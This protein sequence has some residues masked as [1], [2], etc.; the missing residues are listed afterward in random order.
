M[1]RNNFKFIIIITTH[2][3]FIKNKGEA[4]EI[5]ESTLIK[6]NIKNYDLHLSNHKLFNY[7][8]YPPPFVQSQ[9][10]SEIENTIN[11]NDI[12]TYNYGL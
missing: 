2:A 6:K 1:S 10:K 9:H 8:Y 4:R 7:F 12:L 3:L 11:K 5:L